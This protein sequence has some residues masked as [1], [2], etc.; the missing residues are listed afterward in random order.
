MPMIVKTGN[1]SV[2][3]YVLDFY[4]L[5]AQRH[6]VDAEALMVEALRRIAV[7]GI[8]PRD[9]A[10][11]AAPAPR[12]APVGP[13]KPTAARLPPMPRPTF[14]E[15]D[16]EP[17]VVHAEVVVPAATVKRGRLSEADRARIVELHI[18]GLTDQEIARELSRKVETV[19]ERL[20]VAGL[21]ED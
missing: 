3:V 19:T 13:P 14:D 2:P 6:N 5:L 10:A 18:D 8:M 1:L 7:N 20:R 12:P 17:V 9:E 15:R 16:D 4:A 21:G 11:E